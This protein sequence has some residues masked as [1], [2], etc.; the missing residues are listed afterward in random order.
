MNTSPTHRRR[1][2]ARKKLHET[3]NKRAKCKIPLVVGVSRSEADMREYQSLSTDE[4]STEV[5]HTIDQGK[6]NVM[7]AG[8]QSVSCRSAY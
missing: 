4:S 8:T 6:V 5:L 3:K 2:C 7:G 1:L